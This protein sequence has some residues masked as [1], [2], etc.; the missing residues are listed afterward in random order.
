MFK[1]AS[2]SGGMMLSSKPI[3]LDTTDHG[4]DVSNKWS[5]LN[6]G[7]GY[8]QGASHAHHAALVQPTS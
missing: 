3:E 8:A 5:Q 6:G 2:K 7:K 1:P 4:I